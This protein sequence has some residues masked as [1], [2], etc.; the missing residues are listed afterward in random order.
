MQ[1]LFVII[2]GLGLLSL[3]GLAVLARAVP[4]HR[5]AAVVELA[6]AGDLGA[7]PHFPHT[8]QV[9]NRALAPSARRRE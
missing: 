5:L 2:A 1:I 3:C 8:Y 6:R 7:Y 9:L 4:A